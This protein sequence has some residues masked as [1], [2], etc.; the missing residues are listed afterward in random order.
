MKQQ[1]LIHEN[2]IEHRKTF[3]KK[4]KTYM[5]EIM[6]WLFLFS[7]IIW[8]LLLLSNKV[9]AAI[10]PYTNVFGLETYRMVERVG[11]CNVFANGY[12]EEL[13]ICPEDLK[14]KDE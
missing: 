5:N 10:E 9:F 2:V 14:V 1:V 4:P 11:E 3:V 12:Q 7:G 6:K 8:F 13:K